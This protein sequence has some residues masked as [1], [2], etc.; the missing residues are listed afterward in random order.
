LF[1]E[2]ELFVQGEKRLGLYQVQIARPL[3]TG[4]AA[5]VPPL[6]AMVTNFRLI[7]QPQTR[8]PYE[9][10]SIPSTYIVKV[11]D[12]ML[13]HRDGVLVALKTGHQLNMYVGL[14]QIKKFGK[15]LKQMLTPPVRGHFSPQLA[16]HDINRLIEFINR[17]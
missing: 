12:V 5:A 9:P 17:L 16:E 1:S 7:L 10:A 8:K 6:H 4:W 2:T 11:S 15:D 3:S 14:D 13:G